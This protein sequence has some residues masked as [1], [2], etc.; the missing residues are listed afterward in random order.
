MI[1]RIRGKVWEALP[2]RLV[3]DVQGVGY[4]VIV[5]MSTYDALNPVLGAEIELRTYLHIREN[6]HTLYGFATDAE[7]DLFL[8][9][10]ERVTGIGPAIG[11]A[12]LSG[13]PVDH[14]KACVVGG[15]AAALTRIKG[16]GKKTAER[17]ILELK[18]KVGV[19]ESW[20]A[21]AESS[22]SHAAV[23]AE[24]ALIGLGYK[25]AEARK[26]V[27][28][29]AKLNTSAATEDLLRDALRMLNS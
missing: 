15:D 19:A 17:I 8:L 10:I 24:S 4:Q 20:Q 25:Q 2:G 16:L 9:L 27:A 11:M 12:V 6:A 5:A 26:A 22:V 14:F 1:A 28:A 7:K 21:A 3:V 18:D 29:V 13:M 23:D